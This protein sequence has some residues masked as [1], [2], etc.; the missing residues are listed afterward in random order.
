MSA[1]LH[2]ILANALAAALLALAAWG[3]ARRV[4]RQSLVHG[5]WVLA[6]V[7]LVTPP[8]LPLP[9]LPEWKMP[10]LSTPEGPVMVVIEAEGDAATT[11]PA[12][13]TR[14]TP[15]PVELLLATE[16]AALLIDGCEHPPAALVA[17]G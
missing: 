7:K 16:G 1:L 3:I 15:T 11:G 8:L 5:L 17:G 12:I 2:L 14:S 4:R 13:P 9:L 10:T 6:L